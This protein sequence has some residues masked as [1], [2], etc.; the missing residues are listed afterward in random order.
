VL[1]EAA[2]RFDA[3][4]DIRW[5]AFELRPEPIRMPDPDSE[6]IREHWENR[7]L[8]MAAERGLVMRI[9]RRRVRS[10]RALQAALFARE[11]GR[12]HELDRW[13]FRARFEEDADISDIEVL[14]RIAREAGLDEDALAYAV[15]ANSYLNE[16]SADVMLATELG[17]TGVPCAMVGP[18]PPPEAGDPREFYADAEPVVGAVPYEWLE[19][20]IERALGGD[21][22]HARLRR[23]FRPDIKIE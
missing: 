2:R 6:Y 8:P 4:I 10:R 11:H 13:L 7:V 21:R 5:H 20:A 14:K 12:F 9:P 15:T 19:G 16:L 23:R 18:E 1:E 22:T 17:I 3:Q